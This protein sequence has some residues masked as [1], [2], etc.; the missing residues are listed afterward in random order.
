MNIFNWLNMGQ[1][2]I[3]YLDPD[4]LTWTENGLYVEG[5]NVKSSAA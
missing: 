1:F 5:L 3:V 2:S 4:I